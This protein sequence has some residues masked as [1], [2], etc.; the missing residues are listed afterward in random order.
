MKSIVCDTGALISLEKISHGYVFIE[1]LYNKLLI[2]PKVLE[3][4]ACSYNYS[5]EYLTTHNI[6][7]LV[8]VVKDFSIIPNLD[9]LDDGEIEAISLA[10]SLNLE[11]LI[12]ERDG[13]II[14]QKLGLKISGIAGQIIKAFKNGLIDQ[15]EVLY[16]LHELYKQHR[17]N[18]ILYEELKNHIINLG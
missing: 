12:E 1:K 6:S 10:K 5:N 11:L 7:H 17:I 13:R 15:T 8:E 3:E 2:P 14:A 18:S 9:S 4:V 16:K